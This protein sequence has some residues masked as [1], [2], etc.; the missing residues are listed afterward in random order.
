MY[1]LCRRRRFRA[2]DDEDAVL[3]DFLSKNGRIPSAA[4]KKKD[5]GQGVSEFDLPQLLVGCMDAPPHAHAANKTLSLVINEG[6]P[7]LANAS[8]FVATWERERSVSMH[9]MVINQFPTVLG[10]KWRNKL[11]LSPPPRAFHFVG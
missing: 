6:A 10:A 2:F 11:S 3:F 4:K 5:F 9:K 1:L 7:N 8:L